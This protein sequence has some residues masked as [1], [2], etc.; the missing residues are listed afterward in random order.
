M[1][2][3]VIFVT[4]AHAAAWIAL[5][6]ADYLDE[7][8]ESDLALLLFFAGPALASIL[9]LVFRKKIWEKS[10]LAWWQKMLIGAGLWL[11]GSAVFG[12]PIC[13]LVNGNRWIVRQS[14][15]GVENLVNGMEYMVFAV[16]YAVIVFAVILLSET[17][18]FLL[19]LVQKITAR[20]QEKRMRELE[21]T[22]GLDKAE[23]PKEPKKP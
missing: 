22:G 4:A 21:E 12:I 18:I 1:K 5:T 19:V 20:N 11:G 6:I 13:V 17:V 14:M 9:Y 3:P 8:T 2:R 23:E 15:E 16:F 7:T 10:A